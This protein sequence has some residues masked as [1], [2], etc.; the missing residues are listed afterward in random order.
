[1]NNSLAFSNNDLEALLS[2][3]DPALTYNAGR[4]P[5]PEFDLAFLVK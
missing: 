1:L 5:F 3:P 4:D 2:S